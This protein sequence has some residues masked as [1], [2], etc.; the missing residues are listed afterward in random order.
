M[1]PKEHKIDKE[2]AVGMTRQITFTIPQTLEII[3][4]M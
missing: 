3:K 2:T 4:T 1:A